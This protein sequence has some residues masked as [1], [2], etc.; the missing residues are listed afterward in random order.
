MRVSLSLSIYLS[1]FS[2]FLFRFNENEVDYV[3]RLA[4][5]DLLCSVQEIGIFELFINPSRNPVTV[6]SE[7]NRKSAFSERTMIRERLNG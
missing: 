5:R 2:R 4:R 1:L 3:S 6:V 7:K